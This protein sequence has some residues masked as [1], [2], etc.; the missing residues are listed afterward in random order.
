ML[1]E[2][3]TKSGKNLFRKL[4]EHS[5]ELQTKQAEIAKKHNSLSSQYQELEHLKANMNEYLGRDKAE[6]KKESIIGAIKSCKD[7]DNEEPKEKIEI[8]KEFER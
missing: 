8:G 3:K 7:E 5:E 1:G 6:K 4:N 2:L